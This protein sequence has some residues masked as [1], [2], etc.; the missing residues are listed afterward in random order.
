MHTGSEKLDEREL[1]V[2]YE[3][4]RHSYI[5]FSVIAL[6][7]TQISALTGFGERWVSNSTDQIVFSCFFYLSHTFPTS[8][9]AWT[10]KEIWVF[11]KG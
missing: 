1:L 7:L 10:A 2:T 5:I 6:I 8:V 11:G 9:I 4:L 3:P